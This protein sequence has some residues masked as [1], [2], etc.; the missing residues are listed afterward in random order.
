MDRNRGKPAVLLR[1]LISKVQLVLGILIVL[2]FGLAGLGMLTDPS[3]L[4]GGA[5]VVLIL[6]LVLG[7]WLIRRAI[8]KGRLLKRFKQY[9]AALSND[10]LRSL[11]NL[12]LVLNLPADQVRRDVEQMVRLGF[13][14][15]AYINRD[16]NCL[17]LVPS[18][19]G[20][21]PTG[22]SP[23]SGA[24]PAV[25][26]V[27]CRGCG[28]VNHVIPGRSAECEFCGSKLSG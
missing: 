8:L 15:S 25:T 12:A 19:Q 20:A 14:A 27:V 13:F 22:P 26:A 2:F 9:A 3:I 11:D 28:A 4:D 18:A 21:Q 5:L 10:S 7:G 23:V 1:S 24:A 6:M 16:T 17:V